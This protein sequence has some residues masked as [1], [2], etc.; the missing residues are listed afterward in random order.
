ME[1]WDN[2]TMGWWVALVRYSDGKCGRILTWSTPLP[3]AITCTNAARRH[4]SRSVASL[5][6]PNFDCYVSA[7]VT[8][9]QRYSDPP[10]HVCPPSLDSPPK[11]QT[12]RH[13]ANSH[14]HTLS[15]ASV[16]ILRCHDTIQSK[17]NLNAHLFIVY[18]RELTHTIIHIRSDLS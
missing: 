16:L 2:G 6:P 9:S 7:A 5:Y 14:A 15:C 13:I 17:C 10:R 11:T 3:Q 8:A 1:Q 4:F 18:F 12:R